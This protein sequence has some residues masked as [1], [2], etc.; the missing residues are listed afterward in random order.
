MNVLAV[1]LDAERDLASALGWSNLVNVGHALLGTPPDGG[2]NS[3]GQAMVPMW[4]RDW[5][6][7]G[8]L[9]VQYGVVPRYMVRREGEFV[10]TVLIPPVRIK[11]D[12]L[13]KNAAFRLVIVYEATCVAHLRDSRGG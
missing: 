13:D 1:Q 12:G 9:M 2:L 3:R 5:S 4:T 7:C 6:A 10:Q 8:P 11:P